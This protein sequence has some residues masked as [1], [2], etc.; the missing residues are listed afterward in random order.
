MRRWRFPLVSL[1]CAASFFVSLGVQAQVEAETAS[2]SLWQQE[3]QQHLQ[4]QP[5]WQQRNFKISWPRRLPKL[6]AC[7]APL[8]IRTSTRALPAGW[9]ALSLHCQPSR[10]TRS[11]EVRVLVLQ[12]HLVADQNLM[13]GHVLTERDLRWA[14]TDSALVGEGVAMELAQAVGQELRRPVTR[15]SPLRLNNLQDSTVI[16]KGAMVTV[17]VKGSGFELETQGQ[18][19]DNAP[20]GGTLRVTIK[21]GTV[22]PARVISNGL[23]LA[24]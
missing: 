13:P 11:L 1:L 8:D 12:R 22:L 17:I 3:V 21:Q 2:L 5:L 6:P 15:G 18:A 4:A 16:N 14:E 19:M 23:V 24:Q 7:P 9:L 20:M 10:W